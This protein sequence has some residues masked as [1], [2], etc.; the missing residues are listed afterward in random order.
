[1]LTQL[2]DRPS[3]GHSECHIVLQFDCLGNHVCQLASLTR[4]HLRKP[5]QEP[6]DGILHRRG[7]TE[8]FHYSKLDC[9]KP[10]MGLLCDGFYDGVLHVDEDIH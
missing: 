10:Y 7:H 9:A 5:H 3:E 1:M 4:K 6:D 8:T 2:L